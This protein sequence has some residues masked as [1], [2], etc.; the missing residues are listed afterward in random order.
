MT[1]IQ[2]EYTLKELIEKD[3]LCENSGG[4]KFIEEIWGTINNRKI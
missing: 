2:K 3:N 4:S 1:N